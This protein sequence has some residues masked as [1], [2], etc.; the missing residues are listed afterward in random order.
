MEKLVNKKKYT[1]LHWITGMILLLLFISAAILAAFSKVSMDNLLAQEIENRQAILKL[2]VDN[3]NTNLSSLQGYLYQHFTDSEEITMIE[4]GTDNTKVF[5]AKQSLTRNLKKIAGWNDSLEFL[6]FYSPPS[7]DKVLLQVSAKQ[8]D[9]PER[10]DLER[11]VKEY[12]DNKLEKGSSLGRG[13]LLLKNASRGYV[14][15]FY[16]IR[17]SYLGMCLDGRA[18]LEPLKGLASE[19]GC[20]A[21]LAD[22]D[23]NII[24]QTEGFQESIDIN[25]NGR[26]LKKDGEQYLQLNYLSE[27]GD[28]YIGTWTKASLVNG[29]LK[30]MRNLIA[31]FVAGFL[32]VIAAMAFSIRR[33]LYQP[34]RS[35]ELA[36]K[37]VGDGEWD[38]VVKEDSRI[39]EYSSMIHNFNEMVSEIKG[40][41]IQNYENELAAQKSY[42][43]CLQL[44]INPHFYLNA[45]NIIYSLAE[46]HD[47]ALIQEMTMSLVEYSR[48]MFRR[49]ENL[50]TVSQE[51]EHVDNYMKI[52]KMRFPD[53]IEYQANIS[54]EIE[55]AMIPPFVIQSFVENS[56]KYAVSFEQHNR[57]SVCGKL[58]EID[59]ELY[60]QIEIRDNG[61]GYSQEV[62]EAMNEQKPRDERFNI[63]ILN[64]RQRLR[65]IF[66]DKAKMELK[67][68]EGAVTIL[69]IPLTWREDTEE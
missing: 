29:Q 12:I 33:S 28:F 7:P 35:M 69:L 48:Y 37:K 68:E 9:Y 15:R 23:G 47:Y 1:L 17:N 55:D 46:V 32:V 3:A 66:G 65:F 11:Q 27:Q 22:V 39:S 34:I 8:A 6:F 13:Y 21:F 62:L 5:M 56:I 41:K 57:L 31:A 4:T 40:L 42:L 38:L 30:W 43:Q 45:L 36:M 24:S 25:N 54:S 44:Q 10:K 16:K 61:T 20:L 60:V 51:I 52:Q 26:L 2:N 59:G 19:E 18:V 67:N 49:P 53:R 50:V 63:G 64:V 58:N 14:I